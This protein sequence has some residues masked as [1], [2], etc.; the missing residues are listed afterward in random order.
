MTNEQ[1]AAARPQDSTPVPAEASVVTAGRSGNPIS[2]VRGLL[3]AAARWEMLLLAILAVVVY[4]GMQISPY[5]LQLDFWNS[6]NFGASVSGTMEVAIMALAMTPIIITGDIDLSVESMVGLSGA[7]LGVLWVAGLPLVVVIP[8]VLGVGVLGGLFNGLMVTRLG[9][10]ALVVTLGTLA[11]YRGLAN[12]V[13]GTSYVSNFPSELTTFGFGYV[14][15]TAVP[16]TLL[17]FLILAV[18]FTAVMHLTW[19]GRQVFAVGKNKDA[20]RYSGV[21]VASLRTAL[22]AVSGLVAAFAGIVLASRYNS[23]R[24]DNGTGLTLTVVLIVVLGGVDI[25][26]GKG[27]IPGVILAVFTLAAL[28]S[29]LRLAGVSSEYQNVAIGLLLIFSVITPQIARQFRVLVDRV[30]SGRHR[31]VRDPVPGEVVR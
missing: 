30:R 3:S 19:I 26:G 4:E 27:T 9:L 11:L 16:W 10:P 15:G 12:A 20:A 13:L 7:V 2:W 5:F 22:F 29:A 17:A 25:N 21:R 18:V 6:P 14:P 23:V 28:Q 8:I 1:P 24:A 31:P